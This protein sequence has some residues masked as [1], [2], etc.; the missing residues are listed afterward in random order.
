MFG[1]SKNLRGNV[2][3]RKQREMIEEKIYERK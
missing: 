2:R 3:K 1:Y